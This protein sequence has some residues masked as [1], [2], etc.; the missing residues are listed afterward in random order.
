MGPTNIANLQDAFWCWWAT[1]EARVYVCRDLRRP[2]STLSNRQLRTQVFCLFERVQ[3]QHESAV[4]YVP[5][6]GLNV[7]I[8]QRPARSVHPSTLPQL[9]IN[10]PKLSTVEKSKLRHPVMYLLS[11]LVFILPDI[12]CE[13]NI[14]SAQPGGVSQPTKIKLNIGWV[15]G[16]T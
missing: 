14:D 5:W 16:S 8:I 1:S 9:E 4:K 13:R 6:P 7:S 11:W 2:L 10:S 3:R 15:P 12:L